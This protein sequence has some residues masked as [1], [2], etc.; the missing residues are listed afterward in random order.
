[1][2][3][4]KRAEFLVASTKN[5]FNLCYFFIASSSQTVS[6][7]IFSKIIMKVKVLELTRRVWLVVPEAL[8]GRLD[9]EDLH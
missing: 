7:V 3:A 8:G 6:D 1:M 4:P 2:R 9:A 5:K